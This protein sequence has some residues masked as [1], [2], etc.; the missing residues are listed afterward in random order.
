MVTLIVAMYRIYTLLVY[1]TEGRGL[2][3]GTTVVVTFVS[4]LTAYLTV[5]LL[6]RAPDLLGLGLLFVWFGGPVHFGYRSTFLLLH[7]CGGELLCSIV[8]FRRD[9]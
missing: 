3:G 7:W 6:S 2:D 5:I 4:T 1:G 9:F 8:C